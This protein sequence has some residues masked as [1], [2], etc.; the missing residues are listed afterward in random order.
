LALTSAAGLTSLAIASPAAA[1]VYRPTRTSD[2][3]PGKCKPSD[4]SLRE[5]VLAANSN[6][7]PDT[8]VLK[9]G[10][11]YKLAIS[12]RDED[13]GM[14]GDLDVTDALTVKGANPG[15][16]PG[17]HDLATI[18]A[19]SL[20]RIFDF[21]QLTPPGTLH[22]LL[23]TGG[24]PR[25]PNAGSGGAVESYADLT[26]SDCVVMGNRAIVGGGIEGTG[27]A[28]L[29]ITHSEVSSNQANSYGGGIEGNGAMRIS[30]T[31]IDNNGATNFEGGGVYSQFGPDRW[32]DVVLKKNS[33]QHEGGGAYLQGN[34][35]A[36]GL[37]AIRNAA[38]A[39]G[40]ALWLGSP[41]SHATIGTSTL[42]HNLSD[43]GQGGGIWSSGQ[44]KL[45]RSTLS[46]NTSHLGGGGVV[47][48][49][50]SG[51]LTLTNDTIAGN[52]SD[53]FGGGIGD[54]SD[55]TLALNA[56]TLA[57]NMADADNTGGGQGGG[58]QVTTGSTSSIR[59]SI[60]ALNTVGTSGSDPNCNGAVG[61]A[62]HNVIDDATGCLPDK[63][64][65]V[66]GPAEIGKLG[67]HG[68]PTETIPL[69]KGSP[70]IGNAGHDAPPV[71]QRG[72]QRDN[73][74]DSGAY[75]R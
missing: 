54:F 27:G 60:L 9:D 30:H 12:G 37:R 64:S 62:G 4:C 49:G 16:G 33:A 75:E 21:T 24:D 11:I 67:D 34:F 72:H 26:V 45:T 71:D 46:D 47:T 3:A 17:P 19:Q 39:D 52:K 74:P 38:G 13:G 36:T 44:L 32:R 8:I 18:D 59:N 29:T 23:L 6:P 56:V 73:H 57:R 25:D 31:T 61:D 63:P 5:A 2:P 58:L 53:A 68:G 22:S 70:A 28:K 65:D 15:P 41:V 20:D 7:G 48:T 43:A 69:K 35:H 55:A 51:N 14:T 42:S 10:R 40:G 1:H 66:L 50:S